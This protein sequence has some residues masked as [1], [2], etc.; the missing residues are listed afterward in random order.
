M[1]LQLLAEKWCR[2]VQ[3]VFRIGFQVSIFERPQ[4]GAEERQVEFPWL[5]GV[6]QTLLGDLV[7]RLQQGQI[8]VFQPF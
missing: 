6:E 2:K 4:A 7:H 3:Q 5:R 1:G 8:T